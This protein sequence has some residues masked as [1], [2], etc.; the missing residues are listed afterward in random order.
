MIWRKP[1]GVGKRIWSGEIGK[2]S[3]TCSRGRIP[4]HSIPIEINK[5]R[6]ANKRRKVREDIE[7]L[8]SELLIPLVWGYPYMGK[9]SSSLHSCSESRALSLGFPLKAC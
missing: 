8:Y 7:L 4:Q 2:D 1:F 6:T 9:L 3:M 5:R